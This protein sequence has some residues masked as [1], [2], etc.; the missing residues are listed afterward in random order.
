MA[1]ED[2]DF[3]SA[4][5]GAPKPG[6]S[7][8][9]KSQPQIE[10]PITLGSSSVSQPLNSSSVST[11]PT[12]DKLRTSNLGITGVDW[13]KDDKEEISATDDLWNTIKGAGVKAFSTLASLPNKA[14]EAALD[15]FVSATGMASDFNKLPSADKKQIK[16]SLSGLLRSGQQVG[17]TAL[18]G[19]PRVVEISDKATQ[20]LN[21][22]SEDIYKKTRQEDV[23]IIDELDKFRQNPNTESIEKILYEGLKTTVESIPNMAIGAVSLPLLGVAA[24]AGKREEELKETG[25]NLGIGY[26]LNAGISGTAEAI[27]E[28]TTNK[29]LKKASRAAFG[30]PAASKAVAEGFVKSIAKDMGEEG[31][32]E[33]LTTLVQDLSDKIT[34]GEEIN[35]WK[36][37][38]NVAN[39]TILG[40]M[41][42]G[43]ISAGGKTIGAA[44]R[45]VAGKIMPK[46]QIEKIDNNT[47]TIQSLNL[48]RGEDVNPEVNKIVNQKISDLM[49]ENESIIAQN[50]D[51]ASKLS[52]DQ[53]KEIFDIDDRLDE[54]YN[55]AKSIID[56]ATMD[57]PAKELLLK[58]L[59]DK[60]NNLKQQK[61]AIQKQATSEVPIQPEAGARLQVAEGEPQ[62]EPQVPAQ[63]GQR[64]EVVEIEKRRQD[65]L[66]SLPL[67]PLSLTDELTDGEKINIIE[68]E[69]I[70][71]KYD[72]EIAALQPQVPTE[73]VRAEEV[74]PVEEEFVY[75]TTPENKQQWIGD[76]EIIDNRGGKADLEREGSNGNWYIYNNITDRL[77]MARSKSDAQDIIDNADDYDFGQGE[78]FTKQ[79]TN[80]NIQVKAEAK[81]TEE[82]RR[83]QPDQAV[84]NASKREEIK[85]SLEKLKDVGF[86]RSAITGKK[87]ISQGEINTQMA[88]T[89][90]MAN[91]WKETTGRDDFYEN[92]YNDV[93]QGD[94]DAIMEKGGILFQNLELPQRPLTRVSLG[95]FDLPEFKKMEGQ[96]VA[97]NSVRDLARTR[98]KQIEKDLMQTVLDY[99]KYQDV[100]KISFDEF[101]SDVEVQVMKLEKI[102]TSSYASYGMDNLGGDEYYGKA[103][104]LIYNS[105][106]N[107]GE[108]GHF[109]GD[110]KYYSVDIIEWDIKQIPGTDQYVA[111]DRS[112]PDNTPQDQISNY[113]G[114]AGSKEDVE[115]WVR[116]RVVP[117]GAGDVNIGLFGHTRAWYA[118]EG[119]PYY[120]AELQ[121]DYF[122][123]N[124]PN[125][126]YE[127]QVY[128]DDATNY[129]Y[130]KYDK[131]IQPEEL[132]KIKNSLNVRIEIENKNIDGARFSYANAYLYTENGEKLIKAPIYKQLRTEEGLMSNDDWDAQL[133]SEIGSILKLESNP[134]EEI[135][136]KQLDEAFKVNPNYW[137]STVN[138]YKDV[139][140]EVKQKRYALID[141]YRNEYIKA[142]IEKIKNSEKGVSML[143][144]F[145]AS[146]KI[147]EVRLLR[148][149]LRN[150]SQEGAETLRFP[151]PYTLA[152]IEGY[153]NKPG[154]SGEAPYEIISGNREELTMGD[155][156]DYGGT[157]MTILDSNNTSFT[158]VPSDEVQ[159]YNYYDY[160]NSE[161][162]YFLDET[163]S[164]LGNFNDINNITQS[165][166]DNFDFG[167]L[168]WQASGTDEILIR[169]ISESEDGV[170]S[171]SS[172]EEK[173]EDSIRDSLSNLPIHDL[174]YGDEIFGDGGDGYYV[175]QRSNQIESF[176]QPDQYEDESN[177]ENFE[178]NISSGQKTVVNKYKELN[179]V[180]K[181]MRPD[182]EVVT[183]ENN[184][185]WIE[186]KLTPEDSNN[187]V[188][189]FQ[190]EGGNI[191]GAVDFSN[192]NKASIYIFDGADVS[193]LAHEAIGHV[194]RRFLEQ[195]ANVDEEFASDYEKAKEWA[196]VKNN[197]W[198][199][200][201]EEKWARGFEKYLRDGKAPIKALKSVFKNL[202]DWLKNI[203]KRIK[204]SSI[205]IELTPSV[206]KV[207]DNLLGARSEVEFKNLAGYDRMMGEIKGIVEKSFKRGVSYM[208]TMDNAIQ[209]MSKSKVY[210]KSND[211]QRE[212]MVREVRKMFKQKEKNAPSVDKISGKPTPK[213]VTVQEMTAL[214]DQIKLEIK[215]AK[216]GAK[217][218]DDL[219]KSISA[220]VK[221]FITRGKMSVT[222]QK[223]LLNGLKSNLLNP[224]IRERFF[225]R[226]EK[227][228]NRIDYKDRLD[229]ANKYRKQIKKLAKSDT[230][231]DSVKIMANDFAKIIPDF[232]DIDQFLEKAREVYNA[233]KTPGIKRKQ[234][235]LREAAVIEDISSF[236]TKT[237]KSQDEKVKNTLLSEYDYLV[238]AGLIDKNMSLE[239]IQS[240]IM[241][242]ESGIKEINLDEETEIR[243]RVGALFNS[244][245]GIVNEIVETGN[246]P[247]TGEEVELDSYTKSLINNFSKMDLSQLGVQ[248]LYRATEA[249]EN[250][251]VNG[252]IDN[253]ESIYRV[254][255]GAL[256]DKKLVDEGIKA[257]DL[258]RAG[259][260]GRSNIFA[261][262]W[263]INFSPIKSILDLMF[264]SREIGSKVF[265]ATGLRDIANASSKV[266]NII[267]K[268]DKA[269]VDRFGKTKPNGQ[270]FDSAENTYQRG[271]YA[272][273]RRN[274]FGTKSQMDTEF[275]RRKKQ[276][277]KT[278]ADLEK[279]D[280]KSLVKK[281]TIYKQLFESIKDAENIEQVE[282]KIDPIN[283]DA[284]K[285]WT[286]IFETYYPEVKQI[287]ASVYNTVLEDD[288]NY[289][290]DINEKIIEDNAPDVDQKSSYRMSFNYLNSEKS[291]TLMKNKRKSLP[292]NRVLNF[293]FDYN[294]SSALAK[295]LVDIKTAP[296]VQQYKGF[297]QSKS[298]EKLFPDAKDR[299]VIKER[300]NWYVNE[301]RSKN[302]STA[303]PRTA[304]AAKLLR[305]LSRY[306]TAKALGSVSALAK[307][308]IPAFINTSVNLANN[309]SA[310]TKG[311]ALMA[312]KD[313]QKFINN[314]GYGI[315]NRGLESQTAIESA[316]RI[317][318]NTDVKSID[319]ISKS[320]DKVGK[321]W[322]NTFLKNG[323]VFVARSS[324]MAYYINKLDQMGENTSNIDWATHKL[325]KEAADYAE[326]K[327]NLQQNVSDTDMLGKF[328]NS[329]NPGVTIARTL[330]LPFSSFIF[331][332]KDK[333]STDL[334]ILTSN[335]NKT[336]KINAMKSLAG[337]S[338]EMIAFELLAATVSNYIITAAYSIL[339]YE[340]DEEE[341]Q[342]RIDKNLNMA[343]TRIL[344]DVISPIPNLGD[345]ALVALTNVVLNYAQQDLD[346]EEKKLLYEY[347]PKDYTDAILGLIGGVPEIAI[348][349]AREITSTI[350][351][352]TS[353]SYFDKYG[354]EIILS[355]E[356][357][358]KLKFVL[359]TELLMTTNALPNEVNRINQKVK[360]KIIKE[361]R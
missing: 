156:I 9:K 200:A 134:R 83:E 53:V 325:N 241:D 137:T 181:K 332:A 138:K 81:P 351:M 114:T 220:K 211:I 278:I 121:S 204:G 243:E 102:R 302:I 343:I 303:S 197:Q 185:Q 94:V 234:L 159:Y 270:D 198:T 125:D 328:L 298:F 72:A 127:S 80:E 201:A 182:A 61:D 70:N 330:I 184:M 8:K 318:E 257:S 22:K 48:E 267:Q 164:T 1:V 68:T 55:S 284:V 189:A 4:I 51:I 232:T 105:P 123:K 46:D 249:L 238:E 250:Y 275:N 266:K 112:M 203:Y 128:R 161:T 32:S 311:V 93:T 99:D 142:E 7:V 207:F 57:D 326:D 41:S 300:M 35:Y 348:K 258:K 307:Q 291:G 324:W 323:D 44:R 279:T 144:Q 282:A 235:T 106:I 221:E 271:M 118:G 290:P 11:I 349:P 304:D 52:A 91:V 342:T 269:Y 74:A 145:I 261:R 193:T 23:N 196:G 190:E 195:L 213:K 295:M 222:Q 286:S 206:T 223:A 38:K 78:T 158:A 352:I 27:F 191:K 231:Q 67:V 13:A 334:T 76:F 58:D 75:E 122:Q 312:N 136:K 255:D 283:I 276:V 293:D 117:E 88:L 167:D 346:E 173:I 217:F 157:R 180:F 25:G 115:R 109:S 15:M 248:D 327:V 12:K 199:I 188:I 50:E 215:A 294:N 239:D 264:R 129:A 209:Y 316:D 233:I 174:F 292:E 347:K 350:E 212:A 277:E 162:D 296:Y 40:A 113:V 5:V 150:A 141:N 29:I 30:N 111:M 54:N 153:V 119:R 227:M 256:K 124:D 166:V 120:L 33:G 84:Q 224:I 281:V 163:L 301:V 202:S 131:E 2:I 288:I 176:N 273:L 272:Y 242:I 356:D 265:N 219:R 187:P 229:E 143:K 354:N 345:K 236:I 130:E 251:L 139:E 146:Q 147:H 110:F 341:I 18:A 49:A 169:A 19:Q 335:A 100:K 297:T 357:K 140:R 331:N 337:T 305:T 179:K 172:V 253:M 252:I 268:I 329:K 87:D 344:T 178:E 155:E 26:L 108:Y 21:K 230:L 262:T 62:A 16:N 194:G 96:E 104:T 285:W 306:G 3:S 34:K 336:E 132:E 186:T 263:A 225:D 60:Q 287:A 259:L 360:D 24:A 95:V 135:V 63:K 165:D 309:P 322:L 168:N 240:Y 358:D 339:G 226:M 244:M 107:H 214:K 37:A 319:K 82:P 274:R 216:G 85:S 10:E 246:N 65:E 79:I 73:Q 338:A 126:L 208:Q 237:L 151:T 101:K 355:P 317:L 218:A 310:L 148:E 42:G 149:A 14:Q 20:F 133:F 361:A 36:L 31:V 17:G 210:E 315:A 247:L 66:N 175:V 160:L 170:V 314:S 321:F 308:S 39:S 103:N 59:L 6:T 97:I 89:D 28:G 47:D 192:D 71:A 359:A 205:D 45:Y 333:I 254:Y 64:K 313:A 245:A 289:T 92:F 56:D 69:K 154:E 260:F 77:L 353:D 43:G 152:V 171:L 280:D 116:E 177:V 340:E 98:G 228:F 86:L 320:I 90:A 183:D 299:N